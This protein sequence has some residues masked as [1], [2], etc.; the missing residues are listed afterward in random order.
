MWKNKNNGFVPKA[1]I[2]QRSLLN[3]LHV[4]GKI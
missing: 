2:S 3:K 1:T 4:Y